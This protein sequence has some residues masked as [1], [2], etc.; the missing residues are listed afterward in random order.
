MDY[1][2][3]SVDWY[4]NKARVP[5]RRSLMAILPL[6]IVLTAMDFYDKDLSVRVKY[7]QIDVH[8]LV[9]AVGYPLGYVL[10]HRQT[11]RMKTIG[12]LRRVLCCHPIPATINQDLLVTILLEAILSLLIPLC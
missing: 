3:I 2:F 9:V 8:Q 4:G 12:F 7:I 6:A 5:V 1:M 11:P 10:L